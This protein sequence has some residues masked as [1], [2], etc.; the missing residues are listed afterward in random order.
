MSRWQI[1]SKTIYASPENVS[2]YISALICLHNFFLTEQ[3]EVRRQPDV[4]VYCPPNLVDREDENH[5]LVEG[6][7]RNETNNSILHDITRLGSNNPP[8]SAQA[9]RDILRDYFVSPAGEQ[10]APWQYS[11]AFKNVVLN[12]PCDADNHNED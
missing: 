8:K 10:Q 1:L 2:S 3:L 5:D 11:A 9:Q 7:L 6:E 12:M 4:L